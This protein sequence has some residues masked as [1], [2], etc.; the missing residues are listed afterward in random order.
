M[1]QIC[2]GFH[3]LDQ[4]KS[5]VD[6]VCVWGGGGGGGEGVNGLYS[7]YAFVSPSGRMPIV[8]H[9]ISASVIRAA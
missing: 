5:I 3:V 9:G 2:T 8:F 7:L 6:G 1:D 4:D